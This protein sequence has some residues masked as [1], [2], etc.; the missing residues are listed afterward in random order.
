MVDNMAAQYGRL[1]DD[2]MR[3]EMVRYFESLR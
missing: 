1:A 2:K 3:R